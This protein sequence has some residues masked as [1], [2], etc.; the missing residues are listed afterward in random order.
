MLKL[1]AK[2]Y[3]TV[4]V[5]HRRTW[6]KYSTQILNMANQNA[7]STSVKTVG[8]M[9]E[10]WMDMRKQGIRGT[11]DNWTTYYNS[12]RGEATLITA[13]KTLYTMVVKMNLQNIIT[14]D[15]CID[16]VK[17]MVYNKTH[18]GMAGEEMAIEVVAN[19]LKRSYRFSTKEEEARGID[20]WIENIPVQV[21]PNDSPKIPHIPNGV[22]TQKV[23][24]ITYENKKMSC[25]IHNEEFLQKN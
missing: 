13:G 20:G 11:L 23:L 8:S 16:Y 19:Y 22:D 17:E 21:K 24:F 4:V 15:M 2:H 18:M 3:T 12:V 7:K 9:K 14:E 5:R 1:T 6:P 25:Y 10:M